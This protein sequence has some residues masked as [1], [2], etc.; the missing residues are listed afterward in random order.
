[1]EGK[2]RLS[3]QVRIIFHASVTP[4]EFNFWVTRHMFTLVRDC[5]S[6]F[7]SVCDTLR[8]HQ[9]GMSNPVPSQVASPYYC[10]FLSRSAGFY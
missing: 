2:A 6:L 3:T 4:E 7:Q 8:P 10:Y 5:H 1:M 9:H